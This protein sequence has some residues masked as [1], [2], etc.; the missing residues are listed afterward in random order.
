M[1]PDEQSPAI[2]ILEHSARI[3]VAGQRRRLFACRR[4]SSA[5]CTSWLRVFSGKSSKI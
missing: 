5:S 3:A 1:P 4:G 2:E